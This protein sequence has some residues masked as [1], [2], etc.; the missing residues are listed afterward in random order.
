[1]KRLICPIRDWQLTNFLSKKTAT[2]NSG[3]ALRA[4]L[5]GWSSNASY[6]RFSRPT[7][8]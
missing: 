8:L 4:Y 1:M 3:T 2:L 5:R 7:I 6:L